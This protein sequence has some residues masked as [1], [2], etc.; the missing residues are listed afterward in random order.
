M[1]I[2]KIIGV[3]T[4]NSLDA[5]DAV[6]TEFAGDK[7]TDLGDYSLPYPRQLR[8]DFLEI[9]QKTGR[10]NGHEKISMEDLSKW[11][12]FLQAHETYI[13]LVAQAIKNL[14]NKANVKA[15]DITAIGFHGQTLDHY[16]PSV[17]QSDPNVFTLQIGSG[18][19]LADLT[20]IPVI[21]DFRS[22]DIMNGGEAAP[23]APTHNKNI[24][25]GLGLKDAIFYNAGNTGNVAVIS[26][27]TVVGWDAGPFND[28]ADKMVFSHTKG[29][30]CYDEDAK[31]GLRGHV[32]EKLLKVL[33]DSSALTAQGEN[34]LDITPPK[35]SDPS[36]YK[37][38]DELSGDLDFET[39]IRTVEYFAAYV[40]VYTLKFVPADLKMPTHFV[41]FGGGWNNPVCRQAF[42]DLLTGKG[43][44]LPEHQEVFDAILKRFDRQPHFEMIHLSKFMEARLFAD[45]ARYFLEKRNWFSKPLKPGHKPAVLGVCR[46]PHQG[47]S[48]DRINR[49]SKGWQMRKAEN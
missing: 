48:D 29:D 9:R 1:M 17:A 26:G 20:Q 22:D 16:P 25:L 38:P 24:A 28:F 15:E 10:A 5:V 31:Y 43:I 42:E 39:K 47:V 40:A 19:T 2:Y 3:N 44:V 11:P 27:D 41:L 4:G 49:T 12:L 46:T 14:L 7:I 34:Y 32:D 23:L 21:Y 8:E 18:Q 6:L 33:F 35:S 13:Q 37:L 36:W 45:L 30:E